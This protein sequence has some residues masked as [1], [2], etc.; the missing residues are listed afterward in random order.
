VT[1]SVSIGRNGW[2]LET[3][4]GTSDITQIDSPPLILP[5]DKV[6]Q[7]DIPFELIQTSLRSRLGRMPHGRHIKDERI[8]FSETFLSTAAAIELGT[9]PSLPPR[10]VTYST[11]GPTPTHTTHT[12]RNTRELKKKSLCFMQK[13]TQLSQACFGGHITPA[14]TPKSMRVMPLCLLGV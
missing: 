10:P 12:T 6:T 5:V 4:A 7:G 2:Y 13:G 8:F 9:Q 11:R 14:P 1:G 3:S